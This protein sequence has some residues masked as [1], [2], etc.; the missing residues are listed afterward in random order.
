MPLNKYQHQTYTVNIT[1]LSPLHIGSGEQLSSVGEYFVSA[2]HAVFLDN[3]ALMQHLHNEGLLQAYVEHIH[4]K[5]I[6][7][8]FYETLQTMGVNLDAFRHKAIKLNQSGLI[9]GKNNELRLCIKTNGEAYIPGSSLKGLI[10]T[11]II[12]DLLKKENRQWK[13]FIEEL[14]TGI[15]DN[16]RK[17]IERIWKDLEK[18]LFPDEIAGILRLSDSDPVDEQ[19]L[20]VEQIIRQH[21]YGENTEG[22]D[23]LCECIN[24]DSVLSLSLAS[25]LSPNLNYGNFEWLKSNNPRQL[26]AILNQFSRQQL[27]MEIELLQA[28]SHK[29]SLRNELLEKLQGYLEQI[30]NANDEFAIVR[31]GQGKTIFFQTL[32]ALLPDQE[33]ASL[34]HLLFN[35]GN[36]EIAHRIIPRTRSL[37]AL[38]NQM[39]GWVK[40]EIIAPPKKI[41]D[42]IIHEENWEGKVIK[43]YFSDP[44]NID[45]S[46]NGQLHEHVQLN[47]ERGTIP[48]QAGDPV[49]VIIRQVS[50][51]GK[52]VQVKLKL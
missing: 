12:F 3:D 41:I 44:K 9:T 7:F 33:R 19:H 16:D 34:L 52:V 49:E 28:A 47:K 5:G 30:E 23:W 40:L 48:F 36:P 14:K 24:S 46:V 15:A 50:K 51:A 35:K 29:I 25:Y 22:L 6:Q 32:L 2:N 27:L 38:N 10:R 21:F 8:D 4:N 39:L 43:A 11:A 26:A 20:V 18:D 45:I 31:L 37:T 17:A 1:T 42:N 13:D